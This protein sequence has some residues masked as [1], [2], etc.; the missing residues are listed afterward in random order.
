VS[1]TLI[2]ELGEY[3]VAQPMTEAAE[4]DKHK[5]PGEVLVEAYGGERG[6]RDPRLERRGAG[7]RDDDARVH[8]A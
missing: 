8:P 2:G 1:S 6:R 7:A 5:S 4:L 3:W